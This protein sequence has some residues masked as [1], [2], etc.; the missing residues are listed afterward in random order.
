[1][2]RKSAATAE[3]RDDDAKDAAR[4]VGHIMLWGVGRREAYQIL[5]T[6]AR[7]HVHVCHRLAACLQRPRIRSARGGSRKLRSR[8]RTVLEARRAEGGRS[9]VLKRS[10]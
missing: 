4:Q 8:I 10:G 2:L 7:A 1:M 5:R 3:H 6:D 9:A